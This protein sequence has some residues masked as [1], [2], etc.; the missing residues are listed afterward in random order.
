VAVGGL[1]DQ[2]EAASLEGRPEQRSQLRDVVGD[3]DADRCGAMHGGDMVTLRGPAGALAPPRGL[4]G[5][6]RARG[7]LPP[8]RLHP[9]AAV[10]QLRHLER[11]PVPD[12]DPGRGPP[13]LVLARGG[14]DDGRGAAPGPAQPG[15]RPA[16]GAGPG[17]GPGP[18]R[19]GPQPPGRGLRLRR[20]RG[21]AGPAVR[22]RQPPPRDRG[23]A[24]P[25]AGRGL[26]G[27][28][29][30]RPLAGAV[31]HRTTPA[32]ARPIST[33]ARPRGSG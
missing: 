12:L 7:R 21:R 27:E 1:P 5:P 15:R 32:S 25:R 29:R 2:L 31:P 8:G 23:A 19:G 33:S 17:R 3:Q 16:G 24:R 9:Q 28:R 26:A 20:G 14:R 22:L 13:D 6:R 11:P 10:R 30:R 4:P 18:G